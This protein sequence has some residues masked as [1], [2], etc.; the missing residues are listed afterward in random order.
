MGAPR[1]GRPH[2]DLPRLRQGGVGAAVMVIYTPTRP[3]PGGPLAWGLRLADIAHNLVEGSR[4]RACLAGSAAEIRRA[5][6]QG[7]VAVLLAIENGSALGG[8]I[9]NLR[10]YHRLGVRLFGLTWN[11]K[12]DLAGGVGS[13][14][15]LSRFGKAVI[16]EATR[17]GM[18]IDVSHLGDPAFR[19]VARFLKGPF[20]A[21]HSNARALCNHPRNL[22]DAQI[23]EVASRGG[24]IGLNFYP[25]F[26]R[27]SGRA[28]IDD[29]FAHIDHLVDVGGIEAVGLGTDF[30]GVTSLPKGIDH[31]GHLPRITAGLLARGY[32]RPNLR[33]ILGGNFL[34]VLEEARG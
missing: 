19:D 7:R 12:N 25:R 21:S 26:L 17:L 13:R 15:G 16:R 33:K 28:S 3:P 23:R 8:D 10:I 22:T 2:A 9:A 20:I 4:G 14:A 27:K 34:R 6:R 1:K 29:V 18:L 24:V 11:G 5:R 31:A 30:D 32:S